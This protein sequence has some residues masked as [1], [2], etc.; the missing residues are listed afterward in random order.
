MSLAQMFSVSGCVAAVSRAGAAAEIGGSSCR[1][2]AEKLRIGVPLAVPATTV[3]VC[4][5]CDCVTD[6]SW[7][8]GAGVRWGA[9]ERAV[10]GRR[11]AGAVAGGNGA[12]QARQ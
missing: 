7:R 5:S 10:A 9:A 6:A 8:R 2:D 1:H 3:I 4:G 12:A 11:A